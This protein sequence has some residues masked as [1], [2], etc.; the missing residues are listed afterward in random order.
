MIYNSIVRS[1]TSLFSLTI[2]SFPSPSYIG[3]HSQ[4]PSTSLNA[5]IRL[6][7][8]EC[9]V[10]R[11]LVSEVVKWP[12]MP[13]L[14]HSLLAGA[15]SRMLGLLSHR[16]LCLWHFHWFSWTS[17]T[18]KHPKRR[19]LTEDINTLYWLSLQTKPV[20]KVVLQDEN[21]EWNCHVVVTKPGLEEILVVK[22]FI[23]PQHKVNDHLLMDWSG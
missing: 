5:A 14:T 13:T 22:A 15:G 17:F 9:P 23:P 16:R 21:Q 19:K 1:S 18:N 12:G 2:Q 11:A 3:A 7:K 20:S 6:Y 10:P 8:N 4:H